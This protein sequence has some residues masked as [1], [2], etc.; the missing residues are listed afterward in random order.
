MVFLKSEKRYF[1]RRTYLLFWARILDHVLKMLS[2]Q[3]WHAS[4]IQ[5]YLDLKVIQSARPFLS[6]LFV[7]LDNLLVKQQTKKSLIF[8]CNNP[9]SRI[10]PLSLAFMKTQIHHLAHFLQAERN[11]SVNAG[12]W[13]FCSAVSESY[14][15]AEAYDGDMFRYLQLSYKAKKAQV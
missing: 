12:L 1:F 9:T 6:R 5:W 4:L 13:E 7:L 15:S 3:L 14:F 10:Y 8:R 2:K 11:I